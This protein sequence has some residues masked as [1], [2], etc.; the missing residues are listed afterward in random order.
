MSKFVQLPAFWCSAARAV[1]THFKYI[2]GKIRRI[3]PNAETPAH[4]GSQLGPSVQQGGSRPVGT[5]VQ[6][7]SSMSPHTVGETSPHGSSL[8]SHIS[9]T[10]QID[11]VAADDDDVIMSS[12]REFE[13]ARRKNGL[14][15]KRRRTSNSEGQST[16][17]SPNNLSKPKSGPSNLEIE[18]AWSAQQKK[19]ELTCPVC[20]GPII[21][22]MSTKCGHVFCMDCITQSIATQGKCPVCRTKISMNDIIKIYLPMAS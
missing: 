8:R 1:C 7:E 10:P 14:R 22:E 16:R 18:N 17:S 20:L 2:R 3:T 13:E 6:R 15:R 9:I 19:L 11:G 5:N 12:A 21:Q 4:T